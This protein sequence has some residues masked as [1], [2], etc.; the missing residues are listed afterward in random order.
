ML[1]YI[2]VRSYDEFE[3]KVK[4]RGERWDDEIY[5]YKGYSC[6]CCYQIE[7]HLQD[8]FDFEAYGKYMGDY[9]EEYSDGIIEINE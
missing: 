4:E 7:E 3:R 5:L 6:C 2:E 9:A 8:F 1:A